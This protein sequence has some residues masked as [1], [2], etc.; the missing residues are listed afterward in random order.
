MVEI[1]CKQCNTWN[2]DSHYCKNCNAVI[3]MEEEVR[4]ETEKQA[5]LIRN[6]P[7]TKTDVFLEKW[8]NHPNLILKA[9][10]YILYSIYFIF[11]SIGGFLAWLTLM[12]QA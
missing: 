12:S 4:L 10:Y 11:A 2:T 9:I 1:K 6:K 8:K 7:K 5:E 3:S